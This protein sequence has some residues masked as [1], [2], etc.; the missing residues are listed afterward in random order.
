MSDRL[1]IYSRTSSAG[2]RKDKTFSPEEQ[3]KLLRVWA[4]QNGWT[5]RYEF[6]ENDSA[7]HE[8]LE[9]PELNKV[10]RM[11]R[12]GLIDA[13]A[14]YDLSRFT[15][16]V[17]DGIILYR[18]LQQCD[19]RIISI[20]E[21]EITEDN[22]LIYIFTNYQNQEWVKKNREKSRIGYRGKVESGIYHG[23][24]G[25]PYG[26][27]IIGRKKSTQL[28]IYE[29]R[30]EV[31]RTI[32]RWYALDHHT[33]RDIVEWLTRDRVETPGEVLGHIRRRDRGVWSD[34]TIREILRTETYGG[35]A[36]AFKTR[37]V[38]GR[39]FPR[40]KEEWVAIE[41]PAIVPRS[42]WDL[43]QA[44]MNE[45]KQ[46]SPR[47]KVHEYLAGSLI[48]CE[49]CNTGVSGI[50]GYKSYTYYRCNSTRKDLATTSCGMPHIRGDL[51]DTAI[52][53]WVQRLMEQP[54][55]VLAGYKE[56]QKELWKTAEQTREQI[57]AIDAELNTRK[58]QLERLLDLYELGSIPKDLLKERADEYREIVANLEARRAELDQELQDNTLTDEEVVQAVGTIEQ[59][60]ESL[61][62]DW[63]N[64]DF[65]TRRAVVE[66]L[67]LH[68]TLAIEHD[69]P[70]LYIKWLY[71]RFR[72]AMTL[73]SDGEFSYDFSTATPWRIKKPSPSGLPGVPIG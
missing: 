8:G 52:W 24:G 69:Q 35:I 36:Y 50:M 22:Q 44:R 16:D 20:T 9:R 43:A 64:A 33:I 62:D 57:A 70:V 54:K 26:Y 40:P 47:N 67:G 5:V 31:V 32:Y 49:R 72:V 55:V 66:A 51:V 60:R 2:Q 13:L 65:E 38:N 59:Y 61:Q 23:A 15:R 34:N 53:H 3:I 11:A 58:Q 73:G 68:F 63:M 46:L 1:A 17:A 27:E 42:L 48:R 4:M 7:F 21:G 71:N 37:K 12:Q 29:P 30:A 28:R 45:G 25:A 41:V 18:E 6:I 56:A 19:V 14:F 39:S 10:R